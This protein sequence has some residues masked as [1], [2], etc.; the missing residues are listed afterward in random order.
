[1]KDSAPAAGAVRPTA[2]IAAVPVLTAVVPSTG[3]AAGSN[4]V[5]LNGSGFVGIT[6]V[7]FGTKAAL[8]YTVNSPTQITA[9]APS[10]TGTVAVTVK[11]PGGSSNSVPYTY[12]AQPSLTAASPSQGPSSGG[13]TVILTGTGLTGAT[14]VTFG[15]T[16]A[17][18]YTVNSPTQ[19]TAVTPAGTSA[20]PITVTTPGGTTGPVY[21]FYLNAPTVTTVSPSQGPSSGGTTVILTGADLTGATAVTFG[22]TPATS[23]T[24]NSP[25]QIT[26]VTPAGAGSVAVTVTG[27]GGIS[28]SVIYTYVAPPVLGS[29]TPTQGPTDAGAGVTLTGSGLT[30]TTAVHFGAAPAAF[31]VLSDTTV[32][33][34]APAGVPGPVSV[35]VTTIGGTS[36]SLTYTRVAAPSI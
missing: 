18:S 12:A 24:V 25:T 2:V 36:N 8:G 33:A 28:N 10:G 5:V 30:T 11:T 20:V 3:P 7:M 34:T 1:M 21:F 17:T 6:A 14:A 27:P 29:L 26:A 31:N 22:S 35:N 9:V 16:P 19:I 13:T 15:S 32:A 4:N 23:Y